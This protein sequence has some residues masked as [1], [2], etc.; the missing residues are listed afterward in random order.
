MC[1]QCLPINKNKDQQHD[2]IKGKNKDD[3]SEKYEQ[4]LGK[5]F[6]KT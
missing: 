5:S 2:S 4:V 6:N 3:D 1:L